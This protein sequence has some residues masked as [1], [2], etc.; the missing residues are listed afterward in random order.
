MNTLESVFKL[1]YL[2]GDKTVRIMSTSQYGLQAAALSS[3]ALLLSVMPESYVNSILFKYLSKFQEFLKSPDTEMRI[4]GGETLALMY[5]FGLM[6]ERIDVYSFDSSD[7]IELLNNLSKESGK[8][9]SKKDKRSQ[10]ASFRDILRTIEDQIEPEHEIIRFY[11][12]ELIL[13]NWTRRLR[14]AVFRD[15]LGTGINAH[16]QENDS[17][18]DIFDLGAVK[19]SSQD[20]QTNNSFKP[21]KMERKQ[22]NKEHFRSRTRNMNKKRENK[23]VS[24]ANT[25]LLFDE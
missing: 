12:E 18:R 15:I 24:S 25:N 21:S 3:W 8:A 13:N 9:R 10:H 2:K 11:K 20:N 14:Y 6:D 4:T 17:L 1:S 16:L 5:E 7:L 23:N 22:A 19:F